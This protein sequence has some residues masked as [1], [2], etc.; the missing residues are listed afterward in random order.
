MNDIQFSNFKMFKNSL[1]N[2]IWVK[3]DRVLQNNF[4]N[5]KI[6]ALEIDITKT[7]NLPDLCLDISEYKCLKKSM[8]NNNAIFLVGDSHANHLIDGLI[9][10]N[11][12][13]NLF[14]GNECMHI[15]IIRHLLYGEL[16]DKSY[17]R[18]KNCEKYSLK[19]DFL[20]VNNFLNQ[21]NK[22]FYLVSVRVPLYAEKWEIVD[23]NYSPIKK[24]N[25]KY[26]HIYNNLSIHIENLD[27]DIEIILI[28][29]VPT[30]EYGPEYCMISE[31]NCFVSLN[32][33]TN[34]NQKTKNIFENIR[35][36]RNKIKIVNF[37]KNFCDEIKCSMRDINKN[38]LYFDNNHLSKY[39]SETLVQ[40]YD[41]L[42]N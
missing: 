37:N 6:E 11:N 18:I 41:K 9:A 5:Q 23:K 7:K 25:D 35:A 15:L 1:V 8:R 17:E 21:Y 4:F 24:T 30:F 42:M 3:Q 32:E 13:Q 14:L 29:P 33:I 10:S 38:F 28:E 16:R 2:S 31:K 19:S 20:E 36:K 26:L 22:V 27:K 12:V 40:F 39:G 34:M